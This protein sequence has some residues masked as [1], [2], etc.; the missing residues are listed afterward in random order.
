MNEH[1]KVNQLIDVALINND[2]KKEYLPSRIEEITE[3]NIHI[4][5]PMKK[6]RIVPIRVGQTI[7]IVLNHKNDTFA[8]ISNILAREK[9]PIP[10]L[11]IK[12][13]TNFKKIQRREYVRLPVMLNIKIFDQRG[14][15]FS[16]GTTV[17]ISAGGALINTKAS[18]EESDIVKIQIELPNRTPV[19]CKAK[20][21]RLLEKPRTKG[22]TCK[23]AL[24]YHDISQSDRDKIFNFIFEKQREW[25]KKGLL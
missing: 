15:D 19:L 25:R 5:V 20:V 12:K 9:E 18:L 14:E 11:I 10:V 22:E 6:G 17:D 24:E 1:L 21:I 4:S 2:E 8:F 23:V 7:E 3:E 16:D 13:P